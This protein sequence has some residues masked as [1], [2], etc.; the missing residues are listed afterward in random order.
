VISYR[1]DTAVWRAVSAGAHG[2]WR[3]G[4]RQQQGTLSLAARQAATVDNRCTMIG[5]QLDCDTDA[6]VVDSHAQIRY[7]RLV[8]SSIQD[9]S[10]PLSPLFFLIC[11]CGSS[12]LPRPAQRPHKVHDHLH[13]S[14]ER[15]ARGGCRRGGRQAAAER[16]R[17]CETREPFPYWSCSRTVP[18]GCA[19][20]GG[21]E[22]GTSLSSAR[23]VLT[24][25]KFK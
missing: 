13:E 21:C 15:R 10:F 4:G 11:V 18:R 14:K 20:A 17:D 9:V 1:D 23:G 6:A 5:W 22:T 2:S 24:R 8:H 7:R 19:P 16:R 25:Y 12:H 3:R